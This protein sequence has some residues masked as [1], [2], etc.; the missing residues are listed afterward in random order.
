MSARIGQGRI[1]LAPG[2]QDAF[3]D[4]ALPMALGGG[5]DYE[6]LFAAGRDVMEGVVKGVECPITVIGEIE[7]GEPGRVTLVDEE[8]N[9]VPYGGRGW[10]HFVSTGDNQP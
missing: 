4:E 10:E 1:P 5:E 8:H 9:M 7:G 2:L 3:G 6:I